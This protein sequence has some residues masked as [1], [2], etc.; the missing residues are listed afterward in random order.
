MGR[1]SVLAV[2]MLGGILPAVSGCADTF[3]GLRRE[4][5]PAEKQFLVTAALE[6][7]PRG[8]YSVAVKIHNLSGDSVDLTPEMFRLE[9]APPTSFVQAGRMPMFLGKQGY[10]MPDRLEPRADCEGE[11]YFGIRGTPL[12]AGPV[13]FVVKLPDGE[14]RFDFELIG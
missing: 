14:H 8:Y 4:A 3:V 1:G 2:L 9:S 5:H 13:R 12:P 7:W 6:S 10:R 11:I